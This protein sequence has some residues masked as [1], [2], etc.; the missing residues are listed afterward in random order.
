MKTLHRYLGVIAFAAGLMVLYVHIQISLFH[1]SYSIDARMAQNSV[2][3]EEFRKLKYE[4]DQLKAPLQL[5]KRMTDLALELNLPQE[6]FVMRVP[7]PAIV[8]PAEA[9]ETQPPLTMPE[10]PGG[11]FSRWIKVAQAESDR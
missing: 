1:V 5:E 10:A 8:S 9:V 7:M 2:K 3:S 6:V 11:F 4:I